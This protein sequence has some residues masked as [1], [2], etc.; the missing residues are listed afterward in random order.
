MGAER[1]AIAPG[2]VNLL[3]EHVDYNDGPVLPV[4]F[5]LPI[6]YSAEVNVCAISADP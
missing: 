6:R 2:R 5:G 3:G 1:T 4:K